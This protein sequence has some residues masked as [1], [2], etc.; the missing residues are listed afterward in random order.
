MDRTSHLT[1]AHPAPRTDA[2]ARPSR[3]RRFMGLL[4]A[5]A[6]AA[7]VWTIAVP[8]LGVEL[9]VAEV[10]GGPVGA[11]TAGLAAVVGSSLLSGAL[12][13]IVLAVLERWTARGPRLWRGIAVT[14]AVLSLA[15][16]LTMTGD[17]G[18]AITLSLLHLV[19]AAV[20]VG[21]FTGVTG[22]PEP[23]VRPA[24]SR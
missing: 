12:G 9:D 18:A 16:P 20:V 2:T 14:I 19:V 10:P 8:V 11:R 21:A 1:N 22:H 6:M 4:A 17:V 5:A 3:L 23:A 24:E 7:A 15:S 13:W